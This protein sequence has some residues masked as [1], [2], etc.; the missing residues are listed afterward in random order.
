MLGQLY[1]ITSDMI[2]DCFKR[3][4]VIYCN[5]DKLADYDLTMPYEEVRSGT[6]TI[7]KLISMTK[8][9][10]SDL[11]G[12]SERNTETDFFGYATEPYCTGLLEAFEMETTVK[13]DDEVLTNDFDQNKM[14]AIADKI[15]KFLFESNGAYCTMQNGVLPTAAFS[16]QRLLFMEDALERAASEF[17]ND[18]D[19][20]YGILPMPKYDEQQENYISNTQP[21]VS[22]VPVTLGGDRLELTGTVIEA[23]SA[24][25]WRRVIPAYFEISLKQKYTCDADSIEMLDIINSTLSEGFSWIYENWAGYNMTLFDMDTTGKNNIASYLETRRSSAAERTKLLV[26]SF[27]KLADNAGA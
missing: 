13:D 25:G 12:N 10:Y 19:L 8:D 20:N 22:V 17:R 7:D 1:L 5:L 3:S 14:I 24:E 16:G 26:K 23:M 6:W 11:D 15:Y 4:N 21:Y 18:D 2:Y 27:E 9:I